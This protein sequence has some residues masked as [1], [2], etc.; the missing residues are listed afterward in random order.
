MKPHNAFRLYKPYDGPAG[1]DEDQIRNN[2]L[3]L[4]AALEAIGIECQETTLGEVEWALLVAEDVH[5]LTFELMQMYRFSIG[6]DRWGF[7]MEAETFDFLKGSLKQFGMDEESFDQASIDTVLLWFYNIID[8]YSDTIL[9]DQVCEQVRK[10]GKAAGIPKR[11][12]ESYANELE[13]H[14]EPEAYLKMTDADLLKDIRLYI[15]GGE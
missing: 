12:Y 7:C 2:N 15:R 6:Y 5:V 3:A 8:D 11:H 13:G 10:V 14:F 9:Y 1:L 4:K